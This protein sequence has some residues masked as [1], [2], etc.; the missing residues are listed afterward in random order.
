MQQYVNVNIDGAIIRAVKGTSVLDTAIEYGICI[1]HLCHVPNLSDIGACRL[2]IVEHVV[3]GRSKVTTSC[4]LNVEEDMVI[5]TSTDKIRKLRH[6]LA[7]LLVAQAPNSRAIQDIAVRCGV[8]DVRYPFRN[9][10]CVL[11]GRCVRTCTEIW[12]A[13]AI[14]F[15]GRGK[16]RHVDHPFGT[17]PDFCKQ[18]DNC[19]Q[20]CPMTITPCNGP[21]KLGE[22]R[23]CGQCESQLIISEQAP[24]GCVWCE[25]GE[26]FACG[27]YA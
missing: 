26:G 21:M 8:T 10:D 14:G 22:E 3:N 6:N 18:C 23:L 12:K 4:T 9:E 7:E 20:L 17:R 13:R 25:L 5:L 15:V 11:C 19:I 2:C 27:R 24:G 16:D 1:P